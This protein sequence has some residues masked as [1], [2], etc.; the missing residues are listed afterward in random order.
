MHTRNISFELEK[1]GVKGKEL[2]DLIL[3]YFRER[4]MQALRFAIVKAGRSKIFVEAIIMERG[5]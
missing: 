5:H 2:L 1:K 4:K 3:D